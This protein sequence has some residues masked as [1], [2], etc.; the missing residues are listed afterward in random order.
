MTTTELLDKFPTW[1]LFLLS[2]LFTFLSIEIAFHLGHFRQG[3]LTSGKKIFTG[4]FVVASLSLS[5]FMIAIVFST[6]HSRFNELK[7][8][9]L[10]EANAIGTVFIRADLLPQEDRQE[11]RELIQEYVNLRIDPTRGET[12]ESI[13]LIIDRSEELQSELWSIAI[14]IAE[15]RPTPISALFVQSVNELIDMHEKRVT[16]GLHYRIA[17]KIWILLYGLT[18]ITMAMGGYDTGQSGSRRSIPINLFAAAAFSLIFVLM[19]TLDRPHQ[20][21]STTTKAALIDL[22][23]DVQRSMRLRP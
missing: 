19:I 17:G 21:L 14:A 12:K 15:Q 6:V 23:E 20:Q 10:D 8:I 4:P 3:K 5:A 2:W 7:H 11:I 18:I 9:V 22:Q 13:K 1:G 16:I